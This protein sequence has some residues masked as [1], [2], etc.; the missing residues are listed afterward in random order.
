[1]IIKRFGFLLGHLVI[2]IGF[3]KSENW[4]NKELNDFAYTGHQEKITV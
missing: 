4:G 2:K 3:I 1:V